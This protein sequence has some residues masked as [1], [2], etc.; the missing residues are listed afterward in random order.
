MSILSVG[1]SFLCDRSEIKPQVHFIAK[2]LNLE[3]V[4]K[5][6]SGNGNVHIVYNTMTAIL[7]N[8]DKYKL[9][10]IGWSNPARWDF[11]TAPNKWF[12]IKMSTTATNKPMNVGDTLFRHWAPQ[13]I[14]LSNW[15]RSKNI[16]FV[17]WNS[18]KTWN[19]GD[20][21][22]HTEIKNMKEFYRPTECHI[23]DLQNKKEYI[24]EDDGHPNQKSHNDWANNIIEFY[25]NQNT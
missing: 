2:Q 17:M 19:D 7:E 3:L 13:V 20:T 9:V 14:L 4:N 18:L 15:L 21:R 10:L 25:R 16:P 6:I 8:P 24:S 12:A 22:L 1:C 5:S 23:E 11:V